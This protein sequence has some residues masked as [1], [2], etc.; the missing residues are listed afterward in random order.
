MRT[1]LLLMTPTL[2]RV[3]I[4][5]GHLAVAF[6]ANFSSLL[7]GGDT[8]HWARRSDLKELINPPPPPPEP[9]TK[10]KV[11]GSKQA[12]AQVTLSP[13]A[14]VFVLSGMLTVHLLLGTNQHLYVPIFY[15]PQLTK[16]PRLYSVTDHRRQGKNQQL[17]HDAC[18]PNASRR[19]SRP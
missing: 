12:R 16:E 2:P 8:E 3:T 15:V 17:T 4:A 11:K 9:G 1:L 14:L 19:G 5:F 18:R 6:S 7:C 13:R 10:K